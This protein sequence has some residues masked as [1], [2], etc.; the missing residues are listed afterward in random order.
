[1]C[2][3][4]R[5]IKHLLKRIDEL[6][7]AGKKRRAATNMQLKDL[8]K[9]QTAASAHAGDAKRILSE[10]LK[11]V[12]YVGT[13]IGHGASVTKE[14][15]R[16]VDNQGVGTAGSAGPALADPA[17]GVLLSPALL[18]TPRKAPWAKDM[19]VSR[20]LPFFFFCPAIEGAA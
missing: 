5:G 3:D 14:L 6:E 2:S 20:A 7:A 19:M 9:R 15:C 18:D 16:A 12:N 10:V 17:T 13:A 8:S 1:M 11:A 4:G